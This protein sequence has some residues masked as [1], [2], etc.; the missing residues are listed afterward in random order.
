MKLLILADIY[1]EM[2]TLV[3]I[4]NEAEKEKFDVI[5]A[6]GDFT[7][8]FN[9]KDNFEQIDL[10]E[11]ILLKLLALKKPVLCVPGNHDPY[12]I[13]DVFEDYSMNLHGKI[14]KALNMNFAG[15]GGAKTPF[16]TIFEPTEEEVK[17][18]LHHLKQKT[19]KPFILVVHNPPKDTKLDKISSGEHVGSDQI[20]QF[21]LETKP[22]LA[23]CSHIHEAAG[24][25]KLG[26]TCLFY[27]GPVFEGN[28]GIVEII[29]DKIK[30]EIRKV[31]V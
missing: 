19:Q 17:E 13:L 6:P 21:I 23:I 4:L 28:Y 3:K 7:E 27:P 31:K 10:A 9:D 1:G 18:I 14:K 24:E 25:D 30:C 15:I 11:L 16:N 22:V 5:I 2:K 8:S 20:R 29:G 26:D 12:E